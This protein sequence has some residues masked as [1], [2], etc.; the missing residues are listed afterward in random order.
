MTLEPCAHRSQRGP[1]CSHLLIEA[2]LA[3][4]VIGALDPDPRTNGAGAALLRDAGIEVETGICAEAAE[5]SMAGFFSRL[6]NG[7]PRI[8]LKL[9]M[10]IDGKIALANGESRW[11]TGDEARRNVHLERAPLRHD[12]DRPPDL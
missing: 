6:A 1:T 9:A 10:S 7:R 2:G 8:T 12:P 11:I 5:R 4:V 3:R